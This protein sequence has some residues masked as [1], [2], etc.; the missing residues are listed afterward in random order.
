MT[1]SV[2]ALVRHA[3][4]SAGAIEGSIEVASSEDVLLDGR[5]SIS[6]DLLVPGKPSLD[7]TGLPMLVG[8]VD[9]N[10]LEATPRYSVTL[11]DWAVLRYLVRGVDPL[12][13]P[14]VVAPPS[15]H[16]ARDIALTDRSPS[17]GRW[18]D[19]RDIS[20][21]ADV[22]AVAIPAGDYGAMTVAGTAPVVLGD[23]HAVTPAVYRF[24]SINVHPGGHVRV[25]GPIVLLVRD[26]ISVDGVFG[27]ASHARWVTAA[28]AD[29]GLSLAP[30]ARFNGLVL[31]PS[32]EVAIASD[33][34]LTGQVITDRLRIDADGALV[35]AAL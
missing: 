14:S 21:V 28:V 3:P 12:V 2:T 4:D 8:V 31:A 25:D 19:V 22:Q 1:V 27:D 33:A 26:G 11:R 15:V 17:S 6:G 18:D 32:G 16:G 24:E 29:G 7:L 13:I 30:G 34:R 35:D 10:G 23:A 5:A 20:I 9:A